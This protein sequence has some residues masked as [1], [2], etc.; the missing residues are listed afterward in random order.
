MDFVDDEDI[1]KE[2]NNEFK[3]SEFQTGLTYQ[4]GKVGTINVQIGQRIC[5][6][7]QNRT[8]KNRCTCGRF[9]IP[10]LKC[11]SCGIEVSKPICPKCKKETTS[12]TEMDIDFISEYQRALDNIGERDVF[13]PKGVLG[14]T[15]KKTRR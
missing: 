15:S 3:N 5:P 9:T 7:C 14:L 2:K 10:L 1:S 6:G 12:V 13:K 8:F 4:K 11:Q